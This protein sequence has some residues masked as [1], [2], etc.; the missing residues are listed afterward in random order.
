MRLGIYAF[1]MGLISSAAYAQ[2]GINYA[3]ING[4]QSPNG[5][6]ISPGQANSISTVFQDDGAG[7]QYA[8]FTF[9]VWPDPQYSCKVGV[10][11]GSP[12][13][14]SL[15]YLHDDNGN[16]EAEMQAG[17]GGVERN[18]KC[19]LL[20]SG[21]SVTQSGGQWTVTVNVIFNDPYNGVKYIYANG[22]DTNGVSSGWYCP[23]AAFT[24]NSADYAP[25]SI[26]VS[27]GGGSGMG[28]QIQTFQVTVHDTN[29]VQTMWHLEFMFTS[30]QGGWQYGYAFQPV[31]RCKVVAEASANLIWVEDDSENGLS[32]PG[33]AN[34]GASSPASISSNR[35]T[36]YPSISSQVYTDID[37][38]VIT[39]AVSFSPSFS[40]AMY[41]HMYIADNLGMDHWDNQ[42]DGTW[43]WIIGTVLPPQQAPNGM[44]NKGAS[45]EVSY[46]NGQ[47]NTTLYN[48]AFPVTL[49]YGFIYGDLDFFQNTCSVGGS[50]VSASLEVVDPLDLEITYT[51][52]VGA[53]PGARLVTCIWSYGGWNIPYYTSITVVSSAGN[54][55][56]DSMLSSGDLDDALTDWQDNGDG[57]FNATLTGPGFGVGF[58]YG[59]LS[60]ADILSLPAC[61]IPS[62]PCAVINGAEVLVKVGVAGVALWDLWRIWHQDRVQSPYGWPGNNPA[63][64]PE[65]GWV[66]NGQN[67]TPGT[68]NGAWNNPS[69]GE[70][71]SPDLAH[72]EP[73]GPHWD[74]INPKPPYRTPGGNKG[75]RIW[76]DGTMTPKK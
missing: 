23:N 28:G 45:P 44:G 50:G 51:A 71:L 76:P 64:P 56:S 60:D 61:P 52:A 4:I 66:W 39:F 6:N 11:M 25:H 40:G 31:Q 16:P 72:P 63:V 3:S 74:Y 70:S 47:G 68:P 43:T 48:D 49:G 59:F 42:G 17:S 15:V 24:V 10:Y 55:I 22:Y 26:S 21:S 30:Q 34:F 36:L 41:D 13:S 33:F 69:T 75:W 1:V 29:G 20:A 35:C 27:P 65:P 8:F 19:Q 14:Q 46:V 58:E 18:S 2:P 32:P 53:Q 9:E 12:L 57:T 73:F 7:M 54:T 5:N 67:P 62:V 38:E 37:T